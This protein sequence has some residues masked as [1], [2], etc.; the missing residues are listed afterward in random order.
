[1]M[2]LRLRLSSYQDKTR[3]LFLL[4][5]FFFLNQE[6]ISL[7]QEFKRTRSKLG[8]T[9]TKANTTSV[10]GLILTCMSSAGNVHVTTL[11][12]FY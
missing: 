10:S 4:M 2:L 8:G 9:K 7:S 3:N 1:M 6:K 12:M 11:F 5:H